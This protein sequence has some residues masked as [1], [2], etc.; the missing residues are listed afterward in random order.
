MVDFQPKFREAAR[1]TI[2]LLP[3]L[4]H[5]GIRFQYFTEV[6]TRVSR[7]FCV[8]SADSEGVHVTVDVGECVNICEGWVSGF[9]GMKVRIGVL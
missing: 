1:S 8:H 4:W 3:Q 7:L 6:Q 9:A 2:V 5:R